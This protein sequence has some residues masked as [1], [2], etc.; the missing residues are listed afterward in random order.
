MNVPGPA[1]LP[2]QCRGCGA[3]MGHIKKRRRRLPMLYVYDH[4]GSTDV[5]YIAD[6]N[7]G[8]AAKCSVCGRLQPW[9]AAGSPGSIQHWRQPSQ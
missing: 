4:V 9:N 2:W 6:G 1:A 8:G 5:R 3:V 7:G